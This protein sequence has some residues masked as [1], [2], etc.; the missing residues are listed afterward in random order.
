MTLGSLMLAYHHHLDKQKADDL[1]EWRRVRWLG[2][3]QVRLHG[4]PKSAGYPTRPEDL[5]QLDG[6]EEIPAHPMQGTPEEQRAFF[7]DLR[8]QG[9]QI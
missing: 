5:L 8:K 6:D 1:Q 7:D 4:D 9:W 3:I 2:Y